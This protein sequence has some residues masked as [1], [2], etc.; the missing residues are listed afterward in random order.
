MTLGFRIAGWVG[1][2]FAVLIALLSFRFLAL[3]MA[4]AFPVMLS[5]IELRPTAFL[6][7]V[8][9]ASVALALGVF[10][11]IARLRNRRPGLHRWM[12]RAYV[13]A[14]VIGASGGL[15]IGATAPGGL[16]AQVGFSLLAVLWLAT[17]LLAL[18]HIRARRIA[19]HR[20]WMIYSYALTFAAVTLRLQLPFFEMLAGMEYHAASNWVAWTAW[21][22]N[23]LVA[24]W[25]LRKGRAM[26][27]A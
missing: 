9:A 25:W 6:A 7:H 8:I 17:T 24:E 22:P 12:G 20:R 3:P 1:G 23:L 27:K 5:H 16:S 19:A 21:V 2:I 14:V 18:A 11:L 4:E 13:L 26:T 10:Q 15:M